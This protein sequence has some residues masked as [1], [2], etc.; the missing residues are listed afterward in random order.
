MCVS[1]YVCVSVCFCV[2][3]LK[4]TLYLQLWVLKM[5][6]HQAWVSSACL[7]T[8]N[9]LDISRFISTPTR[10]WAKKG[11]SFKMQM[12]QMLSC[13]HLRQSA[14]LLIRPRLLVLK[15]AVG[16]AMSR[17]TFVPRPLFAPPILYR[18]CANLSS[19]WGDSESTPSLWSCCSECGLWTGPNN[20]PGY[21]HPYTR[22][23]REHAGPRFPCRGK[24]KVNK[25]KNHSDTRW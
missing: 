2:S 19:Q 10:V 22:H 18:F 1:V 13:I 14:Q 20:T 21:M 17:G 11:N 16:L 12:S 9:V 7:P 6:S 23:A 4:N 3:N 8:V 24:N 25:L 5:G 15:E